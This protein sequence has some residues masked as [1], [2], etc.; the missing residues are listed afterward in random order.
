[1]LDA[2][3]KSA[4]QL[5]HALEGFDPASLSAQQSASL[6]ETLAMTEKACAAARALAAARAV[7][8]G[9]H[10]VQGFASGADWLARQMGSTNGEARLAIETAA[11]LDLCPEAKEALVAGELSLAQAHEIAKSQPELPGT[12]H[13][14]VDLAR[15][16]GLT[17]VRDAVRDRV[18]KRSDSGELHELQRRRR[19]CHHWFDRYGMV[20]MSVA[21]TPDVG[22]PIVNR[23][24]ADAERLRVAARRSQVEEPF[25][26]HACD[27]L[28]GMLSG[29]G[30]GRATHAELV[31]VCHIDAYRRGHAHP[32]EV[33]QIRG[34]GPIPVERLRELSKDAFIKAVLHDGVRI[35]TVKHFGRHIKAELRTA[36]ELGPPPAFDGA[37]CVEPECG[38]RYG[39]EWDHVDPLAHHGPTSYENLQPRCWPHHRDKTERDRAAGLLARGPT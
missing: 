15:R 34:G 33:S 13:E 14:L 26:A 16:S 30:P 27:A 37:V 22:V 10:R 23:L 24:E 19:H 39:L 29:D 21:F 8:L 3:E 6:V 17:A 9:V 1:M 4:R 31:L 2:I 20:R 12:E 11:V 7:D 25:H 18:L 28:A 5:L 35:D 36:L 32:G 38:R